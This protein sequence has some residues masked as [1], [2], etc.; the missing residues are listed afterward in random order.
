MADPEFVD[1]PLD[2]LLSDA[3]LRER[4]QLIEPQRAWTEMPPPG[5]PRAGKA[6]L[7]GTAMPMATAGASL[8]EQESAGTSYFGVIDKDGNMFS[9]TPS[10]GAKSGPI[11]PGVGMAI[12]LRGSQ[13][14]VQSDHVAAL[15]P[16]KRPRLT[17]APA[18]ALRNGQPFMVFG[19]Y[20]GDHIPQ[21]T[22]QVFL[23]LI[24]FGLDP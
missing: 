2:A 5:D 10:E 8:P 21:G 13:S 17:P 1:V 24:E 20:G 3:Y 22:L 23:N 16:H 4:R 18:L 6:V 19:G 14:R 9:C 15:A 12:S 7:N 11:I